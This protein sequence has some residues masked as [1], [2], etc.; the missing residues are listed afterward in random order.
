MLD[1]TERFYIYRE[2]QRDNQINYKLTLRSN[3]IFEALVQNDP[4]R[5]H[6]NIT[7]PPHPRLSQSYQVVH[8][9]ACKPGDRSVALRK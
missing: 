5:A 4:H 7:I 2:T 8:T 3:T 1:T 6:P 9:S